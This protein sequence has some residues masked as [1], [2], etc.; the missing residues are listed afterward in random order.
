[1]T[2]Q[3]RSSLEE[4]IIRVMAQKIERLPV[5]EAIFERQAQGLSVELKNYSGVQSEIRVS[6]VDYVSCGEALSA[7]DQTW[8]AV[9]CEADPWPGQVA[10]AIDPAL[11]FSLL[12]ILLGGRAARP[13]DWT[14]R[15]FTSIEKRLATQLCEIVLGELGTAFA[16]VSPV[17]FS[18]GW[19][20]SSPQAVMIAPAKAPC[21]RITLDVGLD[22]RGGKLVFVLPFRALEPIKGRLSTMFFG[23]QLGQDDAW[24][25]RMKDTLNDVDVTLTAVLRT[26]R[27]PLSEALGWTAGKVLD[28]GIGPDADVALS[29]RGREVARGAMGR[30][31]SGAAAIRVTETSL[32]PISG[33]DA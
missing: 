22:G 17:A 26:L 11:L 33:E 21:A 20:E 19:I 31:R 10:M 2:A 14:P 12:E 18:V 30:R 7:A 9:V 3:D 1:M 8:L 32:G 24:S 4:E 5:L 27:V 25:D 6:Q 29:V 23:E 13:A 28:L 15:S 16:P